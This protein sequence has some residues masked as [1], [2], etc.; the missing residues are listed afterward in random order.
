M[1]RSVNGDMCS[2]L[3]YHELLEVYAACGS[4]DLGA[5]PAGFDLRRF[6]I[7]SLHVPAPRL[8]ARLAALDEER[9]QALGRQV[10]ERQRISRL[11]YGF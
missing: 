5:V 4:V 6:L 10:V 3:T 2:G 7:T 9:L 8:A 1:L 11:V